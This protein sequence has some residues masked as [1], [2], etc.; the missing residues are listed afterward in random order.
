MCGVLY[1]GLVFIYALGEEAIQTSKTLVKFGQQTVN[2]WIIEKWEL[3]LLSHLGDIERPN[4]TG[5]SHNE[6]GAVSQCPAGSVSFFLPLPECSQHS[7]KDPDWGL[8]FR[9]RLKHMPRLVFVCLT[10]R[11][12]PVYSENSPNVLFPPI[13][14]NLL[15]FCYNQ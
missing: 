5:S 3:G 8:E 13:L 7:N 14:L 11:F 6:C 15:F 12:V 9:S 1:N 10:A 2:K 4:T